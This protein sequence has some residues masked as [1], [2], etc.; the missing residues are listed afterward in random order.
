MEFALSKSVS[1]SFPRIVAKLTALLVL[2][3]GMVPSAQADI[4]S[5]LTNIFIPGNTSITVTSQQAHNG[6]PATAEQ[7]RRMALQHRLDYDVP[8]VHATWIGTHNS[9]NA[10]DYPGYPAP[11]QKE[12]MFEQLDA[13]FRI[14]SLDLY[15]AYDDIVLCH[16]GV[17][18]PSD[19]S[20]AS[21]LH[22]LNAWLD[23]NPDEVIMLVI[24]EGLNNSRQSQAASI[25]NDIMGHRIYTPQQHT[26]SNAAQ[27]EFL[28]LTSLSKRDIRNAGKQV[29]V[30]GYEG[31]NLN[32]HPWR[33]FVWEFHNTGFTADD[34]EEFP[35]LRLNDQYSVIAE[36]MSIFGAPLKCD[37][38]G[39]GAGIFDFFAGTNTSPSADCAESYDLS[40]GEVKDALQ[41]GAGM[42][43]F[44][45]GVDNS[46]F[47]GALWSWNT[48]EP[49]N[50]NNEDCAMQY[51]SSGRWNDA[52][53]STT[54]RYACQSTTSGHWQITSNS[55]NWQ[56]GVSACAAMGD[57]IFSAPVNAKENEELRWVQQSLNIS[58]V[59]INSSDLAKEGDWKVHNNWI[60][61]NP[62]AAALGTAG[63]YQNS[64]ARSGDV[65]G[66]NVVYVQ[67]SSMGS[68][69]QTGVREWTERSTIEGPRFHFTEINRD[70]WSVYLV[71][72]LRGIMIQLDLWRG[73]VIYEDNNSKFDLYNIIGSSKYMRDEHRANGFNVRAMQH[74]GPGG[75]FEHVAGKYWVR[76]N[77][78]GGVMAKYIELGRDRWSAYLYD[79][80]SNHYIQFG[81]WGQVVNHRYG[82]GN[83]T[84]LY[85]MVYAH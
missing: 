56:S 4:I 48:N 63:N 68:F 50:V 61:A 31:C 38:A 21:G 67:Y 82:N 1:S 23:R 29:I 81:L 44:D 53:C 13:G 60:M 24:Q 83:Y 42:I 28:P 16:G 84:R 9:Y 10:S 11:N 62:K 76:K 64:G 22:E 51:K 54:R 41:K 57:Y 66:E 55:G 8:L 80:S 69:V 26:G 70:E 5:T 15:Y 74:D 18:A 77:H 45:F 49:N 2:T 7:K 73:K 65:N 85:N 12:T 30:T 36:D 59:W 43:G 72:N 40:S 14:L 27:C 52:R 19:R 47:D 37:L 17:C 20:M 6:T 71:D 46:R 79:P 33:K 25:L 3:S 39:L 35:N 58:N 34:Y 78:S 32:G 75:S